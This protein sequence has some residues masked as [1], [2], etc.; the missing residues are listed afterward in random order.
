MPTNPLVKADATWQAA[1][2]G[3]KQVLIEAVGGDLMWVDGD[4]PAAGAIGHRL[5]RG[6]NI[7]LPSGMKVKFRDA[8]GGIDQGSCLVTIYP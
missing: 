7:L 8:G 5:S 4:T 3:T 2:D 6:S 1:G